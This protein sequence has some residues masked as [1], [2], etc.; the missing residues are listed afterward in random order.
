MPISEGYG[1]TWFYRSY[2]GVET[3][4]ASTAED[5]ILPIAFADTDYEIQLTPSVDTP[6][7]GIVAVGYS[8]KVAN[9]FRIETT[10]IFTGEVSW[11]VT[12]V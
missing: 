3:F 6:T 7:G 8:N 10:L 5:V 4:T 9:G 12:H 11:E 1:G 2:T